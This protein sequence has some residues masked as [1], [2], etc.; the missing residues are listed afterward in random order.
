MVWAKL[1]DHFHAHPKIAD[2]EPAIMLE[3]VGLHALAI[4]WSADNLTDGRIPR[5][6]PC[7]LAGRNVDDLVDALGEVGLWERKRR[8]LEI[9]DFLDYNPSRAQIEAGRAAMS[10]GGRRGGIASGNARRSAGKKAYP[11]A[12]PS[13]YQQGRVGE[14]SEPVENLENADSLTDSKGLDEQGE[15]KPTLK[16]HPKPLRTPECFLKKTKNSGRESGSP[17]AIGSLIPQ[18]LGGKL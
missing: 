11:Q 5:G 7:K 9:H 14:G 12:Y 2:L 15:T 1:D 6:L 8:G 3:A 17:E 13:S 16:G 10:A 4:S 18:V